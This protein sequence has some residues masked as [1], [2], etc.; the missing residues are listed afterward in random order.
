LCHRI[1]TFPDFPSSY[2]KHTAPKKKAA[3]K[4][5]EG[6]TNVQLVYSR[7]RKE[8]NNS[9]CTEGEEKVFWHTF[10]Y[11]YIHIIA[12]FYCTNDENVRSYVLY[13]AGA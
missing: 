10:L 12:L 7:I 9:Q 3:M 6:E 4:Q 13:V 5:E 1:E 11:F 8:L 2:S